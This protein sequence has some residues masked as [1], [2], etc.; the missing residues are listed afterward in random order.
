MEEIAASDVYWDPEK[1]EKAIV[2]A[3]KSRPGPAAEQGGD[4]DFP[5]SSNRCWQRLLISR[6]QKANG[7]SN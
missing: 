1:G 6:F 4:P 5:D 3:E 7:Y 2:P